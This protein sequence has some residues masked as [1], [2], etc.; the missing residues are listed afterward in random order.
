MPVTMFDEG[1]DSCCGARFFARFGNCEDWG[2]G[3]IGMKWGG[4]IGNAALKKELKHKTKAWGRSAFLVAILNDEQWKKIGKIFVDVGFK[5]VACGWN[6]GK[7]SS[8]LRL[9]AYI[10]DEEDVKKDNAKK[11]PTRKSEKKTG[12]AFF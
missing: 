6:G 7:G 11:K 9:L 10:N 12:I 3:D 4:K 2:R 1:L 5:V 8:K